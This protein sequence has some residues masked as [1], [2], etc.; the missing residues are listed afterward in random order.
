M[1]IVIC[2][3][4]SCIETKLC[5]SA[6][7]PACLAD[8]KCVFLRRVCS[9]CRPPMTNRV[10][11]TVRTP[12]ASVGEMPRDLR[13][14][15]SFVT[16]P[17]FSYICSPVIR[18]SRHDRSTDLC[19]TDRCF[20]LCSPSRHG[21]D[22]SQRPI[23]RPTTRASTERPDR[24]GPDRTTGPSDRARSHHS[25]PANRAS[26]PINIRRRGTILLGAD[27]RQ[28][29]Y[30]H[31]ADQW[32]TVGRYGRRAAVRL[33]WLRQTDSGVDWSEFVRE[34]NQRWAVSQVARL[35]D[36]STV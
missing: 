2:L 7:R 9:P 17:V 35:A 15:T 1:T 33:D 29:E 31:S 19:M 20:S 36:P 16:R 12:E 24:T 23:V 32:G 14:C 27:D 10:R 30:R 11:S 34:I 18:P 3:N 25:S 21:D 8:R 22:G 5:P 13:R 26:A 6:C 28:L 4:R